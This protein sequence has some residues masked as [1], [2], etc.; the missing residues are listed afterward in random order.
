MRG[1]DPVEMERKQAKRPQLDFK[2][3][4]V[5]CPLPSSLSYYHIPKDHFLQFSQGKRKLIRTGTTL[6]VCPSHLAGHWTDEIKKHSGDTLS[7]VK[8]PTH[9]IKPLESLILLT[10]LTHSLVDS[11]PP[12]PIHLVP[13]LFALEMK[14]WTC[15]HCL[16]VLQVC[17]KRD[18]AKV[19]ID[20]VLNTDVLIVSVQFLKQNQYYKKYLKDSPLIPKSTTGATIPCLHWMH[21]HRIILDE[22]HEEGAALLTNFKSSF[23]WYVSGTPFAKEYQSVNSANEVRSLSF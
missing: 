8:V 10:P 12:S 23:A 17:T 6:I 9:A 14:R 18:H 3:L 20:T 15:A 4:L 7:V 16:V 21:W 13:L 11:L 22:A 1:R 19:S 2:D 5:E